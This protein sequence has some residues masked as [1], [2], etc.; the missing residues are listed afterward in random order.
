MEDFVK[1]TYTQRRLLA[2]ASQ[3]DDGALNV[4][5]D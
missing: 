3:R 5:R 1:W 4:C 2:A